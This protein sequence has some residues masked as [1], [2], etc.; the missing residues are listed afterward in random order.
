[1]AKRD[2]ELIIRA[3]DEATKGISAIATALDKLESS[4]DATGRSAVELAAEMAK[5]GSMGDAGKALKQIENDVQRVNRVLDRQE[6]K[7]AEA[8]E[9]VGRY[10]QELVEAKAKLD[11][12]LSDQT[13]VGPLN[14]KE[15][16][17]QSAALKEL[18]TGV[19]S[20]ETKLAKS[21]AR[22]NEQQQE[23]GQTRQAFNELRGAA[24]QAAT[25]VQKLA[26]AEQ[27]IA[28]EAANA[29][30]KSARLT[31]AFVE[32]RAKRDALASAKP[33]DATLGSGDPAAQV[34]KLKREYQDA[35]DKLEKLRA[36]ARRTRSPSQQL[37]RTLG[38][39]AASVQ[40][41]YAAYQSLSA[42]AAAVVSSSIKKQQ[43]A[44]QE[45]AANA[46][47]QAAAEAAAAQ[48]RKLAAEQQ[49]RRVVSALKDVQVA[50]TNLGPRIVQ[51]KQ[52]ERSVLELKSA[53]TALDNELRRVQATQ[54]PFGAQQ[55]Q[56][57]AKMIQ[58]KGAITQGEGI[59]RRYSQSANQ[60]G[61]STS[62]LGNESNRAAGGL[63]RGAQEANKANSEL[64]KLILGTRQSLGLLQRIRGQFLAIGASYVGVF[65]AVN[66]TQGI[67]EAQRDMDSIRNRFLVGF[68]GDQRR[69]AEELEYTRKTADELGLE[70]RT[71]AKEYSKLTAASLGTNLEG[72]NT[73]RI[74]KAV[75]QA[76]RVLNIS[77]DDVAGAYK[78]FSDIISKGTVQ[79]E[80]LK[81]QLGDRFPGA[82][83]LMA[84]S[85]GLGTDELMK[86]MEQGQLTS[87][88]LVYFA[89]AM[90]KR[91]A[92]ALPNAVNTFDAQLQRL[93]NSW[94]EI[95]LVMAESGFLDGIAQGMERITEILKDPAVQEAFARMGK[96]LGD[97]IA[98][99]V[100][101]AAN[102]AAVQSFIT[103]LEK[104]GLAITALLALV[105][106]SVVIQA[107][108]TFAS[109]IGSARTL[110]V[111]FGG[112]A[113]GIKLI[114]ALKA[115]GAAV[116]AA[117]ATLTGPMIA[118][119]LGVMALLAAPFILKWA[120]DNF[121]PFRKMVVEWGDTF[122]T[123]I[124]FVTLQ[125]KKFATSVK[126]VFVEPLKAVKTLWMNT[127][128]SIFNWLAD[129]FAAVGADD[130]ATK[131]KSA[132]ETNLDGAKDAAAEY[133]AEIAKLEEESLANT[134]R[135]KAEVAD[136]IMEIDREIAKNA[137]DE[138]RKASGFVAARGG[139]GGPGART[140]TTD[141]FGELPPP[142]FAPPQGK[143]AGAKA[144]KTETEKLADKVEAKINQ[145]AQRLRELQGDDTNL[146]L[147][148][149]LEM[150]LQA[151]ESKYASVF[152]DLQKLGKDRNSQEW[153]TVQA[154]VE[155]EKTL[156]RNKFAEMQVREEAEARQK[157][158]ERINQL[159][160][161]RSTIMERIKFLQDQGD[162]AS[163][164]QADL[165]KGKLLE[166]DAALLQAIA[167]AQA[168]WATMSGPE[169]D[170][171][172]LKLETLKATV[173]Q[174]G[175]QFKLTSGD[176]AKA[177]GGQLSSAADGFI[178]RIAE[179]G[180]VFGSLKESFRA[181]ARD[182][183]IQIAKMILQQALFNAL[184]A[185][186]SAIGG[187]IGGLIGGAA[188]AVLH[189]G[190]IAGAN[191]RS[192]RAPAA[193]W[194][195]AMR[196]HSGGIAGLQPGEVPAILERGEEVLT[197][198]DPRHALN[199]GAA[200]GGAA[201]KMDVKIVNTIDAGGFVSEG[202]NTAVGQKAIMN[203]I[204][205]NQG[206]VR[207]ALGV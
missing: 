15:L 37:A 23:V 62:R 10:S 186:A 82:V 144:K 101:L 174:N 12:F 152:A 182:F 129:K 151:V 99:L 149:R 57:R 172:R 181:F 92:S 53:Y 44:Q 132:A 188:G 43:A 120:Y 133:H 130:W 84:K 200:S 87:D 35:A 90:S 91:V 201:P 34:R 1:M 63:R 70:F 75:A 196:Y 56:L 38:E 7:L 198:D 156:V 14:K 64:R 47:A 118:A 136:K 86:M 67:A 71:L 135:R 205:A 153:Q 194:S 50:D 45:A 173:Q 100:E 167:D 139:K 77:T 163:I 202:M 138:A 18:E 52:L 27:R 65:G 103:S 88:S 187:P 17:A 126:F 79:A 98:N 24:T 142:S 197:R 108:A 199:G 116:V 171:A 21:T 141:E 76:A 204:R 143:G 16:K 95:Q 29:T 113:I 166:V 168:F 26:V 192:R 162:A 55:D 106:G 165:L 28:K 110:L 78:A 159:Q 114:G 19:A 175:E 125:I 31:A 69:A 161:L 128:G 189:S 94:F 127:W 107:F 3:R 121:P 39:Q 9:E 146:P 89:D 97:L 36:E 73:R 160:D 61:S 5:L 184:K 179:T 80:E 170:A 137:R 193:L 72:E 109:A 81:G 105:G 60:A 83:Q 58:I 104:L 124:E 206:A 93:K 33:I 147:A 148:K 207:G 185:G 20:V 66:F 49:Q 169:A 112:T 74:F 8:G 176:F 96:N 180:D 177:F 51:Q 40:R 154:L 150:E 13:F 119:I 59:L 54:G 22:F 203:F 183:L 145:L 134:V 68:D 178:D 11:K 48:Q 122:Q 140:L 164:Q 111:A 157:V 2:V 4:Q 131:F 123:V 102:E 195:N 85:L 191:G 115:M 117:A 46:K 30:A 6:Q 190:G 155:Q 42:Q 25:D 158:E 41:L 32:L